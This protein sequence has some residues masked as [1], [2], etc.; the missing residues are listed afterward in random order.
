[1]TADHEATPESIRAVA[2]ERAHDR[3]STDEALD[4]VVAV[5]LYGESFVAGSS[6]PRR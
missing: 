5:D 4:A 1:M 3:V 6:S 2:D